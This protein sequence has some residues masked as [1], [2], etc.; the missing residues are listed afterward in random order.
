[1]SKISVKIGKNGWSW[2]VCDLKMFV[3]SHQSNISKVCG[4]FIITNTG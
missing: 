2:L 3:W 4:A 1:M